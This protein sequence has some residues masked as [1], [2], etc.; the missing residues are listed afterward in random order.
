M[1]IILR[2]MSLLFAGDS[3][4]QNLKGWRL[5]STDNHVAVKSFSG[6][7]IT[8]MEDYLKP[9][10][11]KEPSKVILHVGTNDLKHLSAKRVAEGIANL[12]TQIEEDSPA[13]SIVIAAERASLMRASEAA[14]L[15]CVCQ[16]NLCM[17]DLI[18]GLHMTSFRVIGR[19]LG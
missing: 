8:E 1:Q 19:R 14:D 13:T 11:H 3:T 18:L 5:S 12:A 15:I 2:K 16:T 17:S 4:V 6:A 10:L 7:N 9:I